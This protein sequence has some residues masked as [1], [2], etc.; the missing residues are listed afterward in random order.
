M[1]YRA[2]LGV[3]PKGGVF[4]FILEGLRLKGNKRGHLVFE[5]QNKEVFITKGGR[6]IKGKC[7]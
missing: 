3:K 6:S 2:T 1:P 7:W 4:S 5:G